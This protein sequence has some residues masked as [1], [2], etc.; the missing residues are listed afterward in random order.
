MW[1]VRSLLTM[2]DADGVLRFRPLAIPLI[3]GLICAS[4]VASM[5][6]AGL[7]GAGLGMAVGAVAATGLVVFASRAKPEAQIEVAASP[8]QRHR[9]LVVAVGEASA[10]SAQRIAE[11]AGSPVDVR[12]LVPVPSHRLDR[13]MSAEDDAR[14]EAEARLARSAGA[15]VAA[16][17]PVSG[18]IGDHDPAQAMEDELRD[19]PADEVVLLTGNGKDP[20]A[21]VET[22]LSLPLRRVSA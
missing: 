18:S 6:L 13:W 10:E 5:A 12:V 22:R 9:V 11:L 19:F 4:I 21:R 16:G 2:T 15:L 20:L 3:I 7:V 1:C 8:D 17:L 14:R